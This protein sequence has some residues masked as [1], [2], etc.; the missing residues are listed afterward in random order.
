ME[1][2]LELAVTMKNAIFVEELL[3]L[4]MRIKRTMSV[5]SSHEKRRYPPEN[6]GNSG[7]A[8]E[9]ECR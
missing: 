8:G 7:V 9:R 6:P 3:R 1:A 4:S 5:Q 2:S